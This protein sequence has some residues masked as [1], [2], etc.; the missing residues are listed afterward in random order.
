MRTPVGTTTMLSWQNRGGEVRPLGWSGQAG[1]TEE[2]EL[3]QGQVFNLP[4]LF[5]YTASSFRAEALCH[6]TME[7]QTLSLRLY[8]VTHSRLIIDGGGE[9][10]WPS[11]SPSSARWER[12]GRKRTQD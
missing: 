9:L 2:L 7:T 8:S 1:G 5:I 4:K 11:N 10:K 12:K 3:H 6:V